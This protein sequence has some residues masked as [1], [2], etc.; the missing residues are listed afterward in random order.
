MIAGTGTVLDGRY[1]L[2]DRLGSGG[3]AEVYRAYDRRL[4][5]EV[6]IKILNPAA[7]ADPTFV[8]RFQREARASAS[9]NHPH[10]VAVYDWGSDQ[11]VDYLV[12][13]Y[14]PGPTLKEVITR[15]GPLDER[16]ALNIAAAV[17]AA[18]EVAHGRGIIHRDIKPQNVLLGPEGAVKVT[19]FGIAHASGATQLTMPNT[20]AGTAHYL[21]P[22]AA[23]GEATDERS[24]LYSLG[25]VLYEMLTGRVPFDAASPVAI[26]VQHASQQPV[27]PRQL[28][29]ATSRAAEEITLRALAKNPAQRYGSAAAMRQALLQ[30]SAPA[31]RSATPV[32]S[33]RQTT[34]TRHTSQKG[35]SW[36]AA[37][38]A[39]PLLLAAAL[40]A[41]ALHAG[42][43]PHPARTIPAAGAPIHR[44]VPAPT[45]P[46]ASPTAIPTTVPAAIPTAVPAVLTPVQT[47]IA[48]YTDVAYHRFAAARAFWTAHLQAI[49]PPASCIDT[50]FATTTYIEVPSASLL[51]ESASAATVGVQVRIT[52]PGGTQ[53]FQG[54][55][56][57]VRR[58]SGWLLDHERLARLQ[59]P[60]PAA[61][62]APSGPPPGRGRGHGY[63]DHGKGDHGKG[64]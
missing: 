44:A 24:D 2:R 22:E 8:R 62:S 31:S 55:W 16:Q 46:L 4:D 59:P 10:V 18:L 28:N 60:P 17:A 7:A 51:H 30:A 56:F 61:P 34:I 36:L 35:H 21:A 14:V 63:G 64:D 42:T 20:V 50:E 58:A 43:H 49:C 32:S 6:A 26:A 47:V 23:R 19:D 9:L 57:L 41:L 40:V 52:R 53:A 38:L 11:G 5:R 29:P 27:P 45:V 3:S 25:V 12:M 37:V 15:H 39:I 33:G 54:D 48:F 13:E 1:E